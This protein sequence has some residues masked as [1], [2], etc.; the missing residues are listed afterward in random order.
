MTIRTPWQI[1]SFFD[2]F[3]VVEPGLVTCSRWRPD[4]NDTTPTSEYCAVGRKAE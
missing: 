3:D 1:A 4:G 2:G